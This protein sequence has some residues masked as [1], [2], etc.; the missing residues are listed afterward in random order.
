VLRPLRE[1]GQSALL[2][3]KHLSALAGLC[4]RA[5]VLEKNHTVL[6]GPPSQLAT[7]REL[8]DRYLSA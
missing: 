7:D 4:D 8:Q 2:V 3:D 5:A 6:E 1:R